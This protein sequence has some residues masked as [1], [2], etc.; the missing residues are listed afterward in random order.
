VAERRVRSLDPDDPEV[1]GPAM[2][3][4]GDQPSDVDPIGRSPKRSLC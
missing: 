2:L 3:L 1:V 4:Q